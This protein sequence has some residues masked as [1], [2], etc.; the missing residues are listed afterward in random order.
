MVSTYDPAVS[1]ERDDKLSFSRI[2]SESQYRGSERRDKL[3]LGAAGAMIVGLIILLVA[4][5][6]VIDSIDLLGA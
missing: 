4:W 5:F 3:L 2:G 1:T 6:V